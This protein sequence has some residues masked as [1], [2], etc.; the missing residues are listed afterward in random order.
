MPIDEIAEEGILVDL[1]SPVKFGDIQLEEGIEPNN[2]TSAGTPRSLGT[3]IHTPQRRSTANFT[4]GA[5]ELFEN[6]ISFDDY[7]LTGANLEDDAMPNSPRLEMAGF[8]ADASLDIRP[9]PSIRSPASIPATERTIT[10]IRETD[11]TTPPDQSFLDIQSLDDRST[12]EKGL[13]LSENLSEVDLPVEESLTTKRR[14]FA[15]LMN[16]RKRREA[17][18]VKITTPPSLDSLEA[19]LAKNSK[20]DKQAE[21]S[22]PNAQFDVKAARL[23]DIDQLPSFFHRTEKINDRGAPPKKVDDKVTVQA[24]EKLQKAQSHSMTKPGLVNKKYV[25]LCREESERDNFLR[26]RIQREIDGLKESMAKIDCGSPS[27]L[28]VPQPAAKGEAWIEDVMRDIAKKGDEVKERSVSTHITTTTGCD[29][30]MSGSNPTQDQSSQKKAPQEAQRQSPALEY[31][32]PIMTSPTWRLS[33]RNPRLNTSPNLKTKT[34]LTQIVTTS[35]N[36]TMLLGPSTQ[37]T[38]TERAN[39]CRLRRQARKRFSKS[40][41]SISPLL[42][43]PPVT[44]T[45]GQEVSRETDVAQEDDHVPLNQVR[46]EISISTSKL[47]EMKVAQTPNTVNMNQPVKEQSQLNLQ[48]ATITSKPCVKDSLLSLMERCP[49]AYPSHLDDRDDT[50]ALFGISS[51]LTLE[52][53]SGLSLVSSVKRLY[54]ALRWF[55]NAVI[56]LVRVYASFVGP[57][58]DKS[59]EYWSRNAGGESSCRDYLVTI[60]AIPVGILAPY[61][62]V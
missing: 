22:V 58:F 4:S 14:K 20:N 53:F 40:P 9:S 41:M 56:L 27:R 17:R 61:A 25:K 47:E 21:V 34:Q 10:A 33:H 3:V 13:A 50:V 49:G 45:K 55:F 28:K 32:T 43:T 44:L 59:S 15:F 54:H 19:C 29:H 39:T 62:L 1:G 48:S 16:P 12:E 5:Q 36:Q 26:E 30:Q 6:G 38:A 46:I 35:T 7:N 24:Q 11:E 23:R 37:R 18:G 2:G 51:M 42:Y 52:F 31:S 8:E 57:F 60:L